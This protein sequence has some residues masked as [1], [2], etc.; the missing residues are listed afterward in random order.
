[1]AQPK[2]T[3]YDILAVPRDAGAGDITAAFQ[4]AKAALDDSPNADPNSHVVL[5]HAYDTL[6]DPKRRAA[7]DAS[8]AGAPQKPAAP[9]DE[10]VIEVAPPT[11]QLPWI[12]IAIGVAVVAVI[13]LIAL[14]PSRPPPPPAEPQPVAEP[15][16]PPPPVLKTKSGVEILA[17]ASTSGGPL[18]SY[19]MSGQATPV[20]IALST[21]PGTM[22]T[23]CHGIPGGEKLVVR[24]GSETLAADV[25]ITDETLD[26]CK[27]QIAGFGAPP[28]K[29]AAETPKAGDKIF[30]V[31]VNAKGEPAVTEGTVKQLLETT[32]GRLIELS[33]PIGQYS[34]GGGVFD[35]YGRLIGIA[36]VQHKSGLSIALPATNI[37]LMRSRGAT[38]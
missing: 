37:T 34:S 1:M 5:R 10:E 19:S 8:L 30:A 38:K 11:R 35:A 17:D 32:E 31:G 15:A 2:K 22:I 21:E 12:P 27:L 13:I 24:V 29:V 9:V 26:L 20:G 14:R 16:P 6:K 33:M 3:L 4:R 28:V 36:T 7:Y 25:L 18:L 23:T